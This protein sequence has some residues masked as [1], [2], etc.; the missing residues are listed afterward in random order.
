[1]ESGHV[2]WTGQGQHEMVELEWAMVIEAEWHG[3]VKLEKWLHPSA[4]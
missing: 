1:M 4:L 2:E 3:E